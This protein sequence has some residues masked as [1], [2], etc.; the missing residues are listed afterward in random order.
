MKE[1]ENA[2][3][4]AMRCDSCDRRLMVCESGVRASS[5]DP[6][7]ARE[8]TLHSLAPAPVLCWLRPVPPPSA[9]ASAGLAA[10]KAR[11]PRPRCS[12]AGPPKTFI[13]YPGWGA[14]YA[15]TAHRVAGIFCDNHH[16]STSLAPGPRHTPGP[17]PVFPSN[18]LFLPRWDGLSSCRGCTLLLVTLQ[19]SSLLIHLRS[20]CLFFRLNCG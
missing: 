7:A 1:L 12:A 18:S 9:A 8:C 6:L 15:W 17:S 19:P 10:L 11:E 16:R 2:D 3:G 4:D 5:L 20:A 13:L 14:F